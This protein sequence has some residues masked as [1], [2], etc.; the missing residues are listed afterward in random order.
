MGAGFALD[1]GHG[2]GDGN[3]VI[4]LL[5]AIHFHYTGFAVP[6]ITAMTGRFLA[7]HQ[8]AAPLYSWLAGAVVAATPL[9]AAGITLAPWLEAVGVLLIFVAI[10]GLAVVLGF[11]VLRQ[12][13]SR[14]ARGLLTVTACAMVIAVVPALFYG[15]GELLERSF[16]TIPRMVQLHGFTNALGFV[17]C[18]LLGWLVADN[19]SQHNRYS[20]VR[21]WTTIGRPSL[22]RVSKRKIGS[23]M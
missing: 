13:P 15:A 6:V 23:K 9:I 4:V 7:R 21:A 8:L 18:G 5:T 11:Y 10:V 2:D 22:G 1:G 17:A 14:L 3:D 12:L 16:I 19:R 20:P